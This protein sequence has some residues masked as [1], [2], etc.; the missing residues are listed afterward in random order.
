[1]G[2]KGGKKHV[3]SQTLQACQ[4]FILLP[5]ALFKKLIIELNVIIQFPKL[6]YSTY[7]AV[8]SNHLTGKCIHFKHHSLQIL[9]HLKFSL[10]H[11]F[12]CAHEQGPLSLTGQIQLSGWRY[13][14]PRPPRGLV[15]ALWP[16][17]VLLP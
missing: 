11:L 5:R 1:M 17:C 16:P 14:E 12:C 15:A 6:F 7:T 4:P 8:T 2:L 10:L 9:P 13:S 3:T